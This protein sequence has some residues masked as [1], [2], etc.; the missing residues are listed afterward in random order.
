MFAN[1]LAGKGLVKAADLGRHVGQRVRVAGWLLTGKLVSTKTGEPME[2]LT[3]E[4]DT[5]LVETTF[6]PGVY[7]RFCRML[8]RG[9]PYI[10]T[11]RVEQDLGAVTMTVDQVSVLS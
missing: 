1:K 7:R 11:G 6:F 10:L 5:A 8:D 4:D 2:F 9:R 3:F